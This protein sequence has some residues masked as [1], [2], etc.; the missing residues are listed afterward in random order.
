MNKFTLDCKS[1]KLHLHATMFCQRTMK[2]GMKMSVLR[3]TV[4]EV[5]MGK[6]NFLF[7]RNS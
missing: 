3:K 1:T 4:V 2:L 6:I 7:I 5:V